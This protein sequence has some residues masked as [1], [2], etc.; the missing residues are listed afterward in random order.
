MAASGV[1]MGTQPESRLSD[2]IATVR[3][4]AT[5]AP[6]IAWNQGLFGEVCVAAGADRYETG[7][8]WRERCNTPSLIRGHRKPPP[9]E[10]T[11]RSPRPVYVHTLDPSVAKATLRRIAQLR[12][13][14]PDLPCTDIA[15]CPGGSAGLLGDARM[16]A[17]RAR[18][19]SMDELSRVDPAFR[20]SHLVGARST[21]PWT[22]TASVRCTDG[23]P[24]RPAKPVRH[25]PATSGYAADPRCC[26]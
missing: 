3:R 21:P 24:S 9:P 20:W 6:V 2:L 25:S 4:T 14:S 26:C 12:S 19:H 7:I 23:A 1:D 17:I 11:P 22:G 15:C 10:G 18:A 13:I 8:G 16:H 5:V